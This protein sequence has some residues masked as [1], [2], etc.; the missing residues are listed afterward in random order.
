M[1][2]NK[3]DLLTWLMDVSD[4]A[5]IGIEE[6]NFGQ[7]ALIAVHGDDVS[8]LEVGDVPYPTEKA[9][10]EASREK[11][12]ERLQEIDAEAEDK[13]TDTG[14]MI[15]TLEGCISGDPHLFSANFDDAFTFKDRGQAEAFV[16]EFPDVLRLALILNS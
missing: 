8:L 3:H 9:D 7:L 16:E 6:G 10:T 12:L 14:V 11:M 1:P 5:E 4:D 13:E 15:V 2:T